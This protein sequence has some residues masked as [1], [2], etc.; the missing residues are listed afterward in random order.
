MRTYFI[1]IIFLV[2]FYNLVFAD[3]ML[4][5]QDCIREAAK[6]HPDLIAAVEEIKQSEAAKKI[7]ASALYPQIDANIDA[8]TGR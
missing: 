3:E 7:T 2:I 1:T 4:S 6:N 5:W 8:S